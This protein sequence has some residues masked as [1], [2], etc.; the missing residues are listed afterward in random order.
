MSGHATNIDARATFPARFRAYL[1]NSNMVVV[2][3]ETREELLAPAKDRGYDVT[4][5]QLARWRHKGLLPSPKQRSLGRGRG[6]QTVYP[7]GTG[8][9]LLRL[10]EIHFDDKEKRLLYVGWRL[11]WE[12]FDDVCLLKPVRAFLSRAADRLN[13]ELDYLRD[14]ETGALSDVKWKEVVEGGPEPRFERPV[15]RMRKRVGRDLR[16]TLMSIMLQV[17]LGLYETFQVGAVEGIED[18]SDARIVEKALGLDRDPSGQRTDSRTRPAKDLEITLG[19]VSQLFH[20]HSL[21]E[22]A[23]EAKKEDL[24]AS[25]DQVRLVL[26][27][28]R[29]ID[30]LA[31][32]I[33]GAEGVAFREM[34]K[35]L[36]DLEPPDQALLVLSRTMWRL[37]GPPGTREM[38]DSHH[39]RLQQAID[40]LP[41]LGWNMADAQE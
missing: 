9:Q 11:W 40:Q 8:R 20:E 35:D 32:E 38:M 15:R 36:R 30:A 6:T 33:P 34:S 19:K 31:E 2:R 26:T 24:W 25:R 10:C 23:A 28:L 5:H 1:Y 22:V 37:W 41:R 12:G 3:G 27:W 18:D 14:P 7:L 21:R 4:D 29:L 17:P 13:K 39:Q 16:P